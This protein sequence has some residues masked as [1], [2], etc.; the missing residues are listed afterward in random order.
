MSYPFITSCKSLSIPSRYDCFFIRLITKIS[1]LYFSSIFTFSMLGY[2]PWICT[3]RRD[4]SSLSLLLYLAL[5]SFFS[6]NVSQAFYKASNSSRPCICN[7]RTLKSRNK[8]KII[9]LMHLQRH[10]VNYFL[11]LFLFNHF[12]VGLTLLNVIS[13]V[14]FLQMLPPDLRLFSCSVVDSDLFALAI[15]WLN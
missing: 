12:P 6:P 3:C 10:F 5:W 13:F 7:F 2:C 14:L 15:W 9:W 1:D 11:P 4:F 8:R